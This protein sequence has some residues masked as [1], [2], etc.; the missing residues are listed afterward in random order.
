MIEN[1]KN[2]IYNSADFQNL[3][4]PDNAGESVCITGLNGSLRGLL[5]SYIS[6]IHH[7]PVVFL[8]ADQDEAEK[9]RDDLE[10]LMA[11]GSL[12]FFPSGDRQPYD[13]HEPN[14]SLQRLRLETLQNLINTP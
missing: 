3:E 14:P 5:L 8:C 11:P 4:L 13:E 7:K 10:I 12:S 2:K 9:T 1:L 6:D